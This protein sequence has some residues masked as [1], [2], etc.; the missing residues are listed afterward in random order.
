MSSLKTKLDADFKELVNRMRRGR[1]L[2]NAS[3]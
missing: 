3:F 2:S 1:E